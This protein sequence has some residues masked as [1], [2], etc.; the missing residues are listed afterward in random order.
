LT[1]VDS[2]GLNIQLNLLFQNLA[3]NEV[4]PAV[5]DAFL[6]FN[7]SFVPGE[8]VR[9][10][11]SIPNLRAS[12]AMSLNPSLDGSAY[13]P[14]SRVG[15]SVTVGNESGTA[16]DGSLALA[17]EDTA[18]ATVENLPPITITALSGLTSVVF[19]SEWY[20]GATLAEGYKLVA[21]LSNALGMEVGQGEVS[22]TITSIQQL[23]A[24]IV[25][26][27]A[28]Y[29][30]NETA[31]LTSAVTNGTQNQGLA[32]LSATVTILDPSASAIFSETRALSDLLPSSG[33]SF[34]SFWSVGTVAPGNYTAVLSITM[35]NGLTA[36]SSAGFS[37]ASSLDQA[38]SLSGTITITPNGIIEGET[39]HLDYTVQ[40][41]GNVLDVPQVTLE[42]LIVDPVT[43][44][45]ARTLTDFASL[46]ARE[47]F[48]N[49]MTFESA[50]LAPANY[51]FIL[52]GTI[53][54]VVQTLSSAVLTINPNPNTAPTANAG[55]DLIGLVGQSVSLDGTGSSDPEGGPLTYT[56]AFVSVPEGSALTNAN[57]TGANTATPSFVPDVRGSYILSLVVNDGN[58]D[59]QT[60]QV[61]VYVAP[62]IQIDLHPETINLKSNG[63]STS[64]TV[65]L[66][67][68]L[69]DSFAPLTAPDGVTMTATFSFTHAYVDMGGNVV[70]FTTPITDYPGDDFVQ[71]VDLDGDGTIDGYQVTLKIDRQLIINGFKDSTGALRITQPTALTSTAFGN[72]IRIGSDIN[73]AIAPPDVTKGGK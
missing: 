52:R 46:N 40:N 25:T 56:W 17:I 61:A 50:G 51:L 34:K 30:A 8:S 63:A 70:S 58:L 67:S 42:I 11:I 36:T 14:Q 10:P 18:G 54:D 39:T 43:G 24:Q 53:G 2:K 26:D 6:V 12:S 62:P 4:R 32:G 15:I 55:P 7:N 13:S 59:S 3:E 72:G 16:F 5:S 19:M 23:T 60:D 38:K 35:A 22:F 20:T 41:I 37:I 57:L 47:V 27:K 28:M 45:V 29:G 69:L 49:G 33:T 66:F 9:V 65:V 21:R 44:V 48:A 68:P 1:D 71:A 64:I 73:T 31:T